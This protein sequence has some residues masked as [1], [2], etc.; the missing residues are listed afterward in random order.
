[1]L[2]MTLSLFCLSASNAALLIVNVP[3]ASI[4]ITAVQRA[5]R[6][7]PQ[8]KAWQECDGVSSSMAISCTSNRLAET[9]MHNQVNAKFCCKH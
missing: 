3:T 5:G 2:M 6:K 1:M 9:S 7:A 8:Q 4:S